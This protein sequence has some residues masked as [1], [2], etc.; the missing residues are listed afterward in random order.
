MYVCLCLVV[1]PG[2]ARSFVS[3]V[4]PENSPS[5]VRF[6]EAHEHF[7]DADRSYISMGQQHNAPGENA[8]DENENWKIIAALFFS[9]FVAYILDILM[10]LLYPVGTTAFPIFKHTFCVL[11]AV[12]CCPSVL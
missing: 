3:S 10:Y 12:V 11:A 7:C 8:V 9:F 5:A 6:I 4:D 1:L 2:R